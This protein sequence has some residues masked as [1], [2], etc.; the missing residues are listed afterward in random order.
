MLPCSLTLP[1]P[2]PPPPSNHFRM[3]G[4]RRLRP[5]P[6]T[7]TVMV[8]CRAWAEW[9]PRSMT[10]SDHTS[11]G[12]R[13]LLGERRATLDHRGHQIWISDY[14]PYRIRQ[15]KASKSVKD[16]HRHVGSEEG[17]D[18]GKGIQTRKQKRETDLAGAVA[19]ESEQARYWEGN[20][21]ETTCR[22]RCRT[23]TL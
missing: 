4:Y 9:G 20:G 13:D 21:P 18:Y 12:R 11:L 19:A 3:R 6:K 15:V 23:W 2:P 8:P 16:H 10:M 17:R 1:L 14:N 7:I 22:W 5:I